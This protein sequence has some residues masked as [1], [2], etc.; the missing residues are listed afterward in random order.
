MAEGE[1]NLL[2]NVCSA[3]SSVS[4]LINCFSEKR[5]GLKFLRAEEQLIFL[6]DSVKTLHG[7]SIKESDLTDQHSEN[8]EKEKDSNSSLLVAEY[9]GIFVLRKHDGKVTEVTAV[10]FFMKWDFS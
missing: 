4:F 1:A 2:G 9:E 5:S 3:N 10:Q 6:T 8:I 7:S